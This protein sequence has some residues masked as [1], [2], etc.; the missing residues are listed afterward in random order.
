MNKPPAPKQNHA[1]VA[2]A[3]FLF[4]WLLSRILYRWLEAF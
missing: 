4:G 3:V 1:L 2:V